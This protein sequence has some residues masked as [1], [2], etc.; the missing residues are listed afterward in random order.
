MIRILGALALAF[1][2]APG[3]SAA[4]D[5]RQGFVGSFSGVWSDG[6]VTVPAVVT[7]KS[8]SEDGVVFAQ[9]SYGPSSDGKTPSGTTYAS[10]RIV[11]PVLFLKFEFG[12]ASEVYVMRADGKL[13]GYYSGPLG[14][15]TG[16]FS[17]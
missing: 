1:S 13:F 3:T 17:R 4:A 10:G 6:S 15:S 11:G 12:S 9:C 14:K 8:I 5:E 7:I 2:L 16:L